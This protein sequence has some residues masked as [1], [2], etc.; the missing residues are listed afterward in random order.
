MQGGFTTSITRV[1]QVEFHRF[2]CTAGLSVG[3]ITIN[4]NYEPQDSPADIIEVSNHWRIIK[5]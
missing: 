2:I 4:M 1:V 3:S 5:C